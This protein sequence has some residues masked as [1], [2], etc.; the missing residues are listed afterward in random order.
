[1]SLATRCPACGTAFRVVE[2]QLRVSEGWVR[3]GHCEEVFNGRDDL[4]ELPAGPAS[5][6]PT[7]QSAAPLSDESRSAL[8]DLDLPDLAPEAADWPSVQ[9]PAIG[10]E[11]VDLDPTALPEAPSLAASGSLPAPVPSR[12]RAD[13][14]SRS[15]SAAFSIPAL[16]GARLGIDPL[17]QPAV[18]TRR[19]GAAQGPALIGA[20]ATSATPPTPSSAPE[21]L[22]MRELPAAGPPA[23][24]TVA[25]DQATWQHAPARRWTQRAA[26]LLAVLLVAQTAY[27]LRNSL[28]LRWPQ[29][30]A[31]ASA[32][33][34]RLGC[35]LMA[36][37]RM[38]DALSVDSASLIREPAPGA[39]RLDVTLRNRAAAAV[40]LPAFELSLSDEQ[41]TVIARRVFLPAELGVAGTVRPGADLSVHLPLTITLP[42][43]AGFA[44]EIFYP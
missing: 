30:A 27:A 42:K 12:P 21:P 15:P 3:C 8:V 44:V 25:D 32:V 33:C 14:D 18:V 22:P 34:E 20:A 41:N 9:W 24:V 31:A 43:T 38:L 13:D 11:A 6:P 23:F 16:A 39:N 2:D 37:P 35:T 28:L 29:A 17:G 10:D 5:P 1:M 19:S 26:V 36:A 4:F 7:E 40:A